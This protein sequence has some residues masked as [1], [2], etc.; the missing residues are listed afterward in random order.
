[1]ATLTNSCLGTT[2]ISSEAGIWL[3]VESATGGGVRAYSPY[4]WIDSATSALGGRLVF[5]Y[6]KQVADVQLPKV[7]ERSTITIDADAMTPHT[8]SGSWRI[9]RA[10]LLTGTPSAR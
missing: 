1:A 3:P 9:E 8:P 7:G 6:T 2:C 10:R 5:G 4:V